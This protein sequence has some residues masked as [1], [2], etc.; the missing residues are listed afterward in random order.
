MAFK[1]VFFTVSVT[2]AA[3]AAAVYY[4]QQQDKKL[5]TDEALDADEADE[6]QP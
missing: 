4:K 2:A 3:V 5:K 1:K 6:K